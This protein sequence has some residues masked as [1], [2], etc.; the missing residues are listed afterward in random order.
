MLCPSC[1]RR[2]KSVQ[3]LNKG[4]LKC[5]KPHHKD[6][7]L[8]IQVWDKV[9]VHKEQELRLG[10]SGV[11]EHTSAKEKAQINMQIVVANGSASKFLDTE[12]ITE[13]T[14]QSP[15]WRFDFKEKTG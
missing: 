15:K 8:W 10:V 7:G 2:R 14:K 9:N 13:D 3:A 6:A 1:L 11:E 4:D 12:E 5:I